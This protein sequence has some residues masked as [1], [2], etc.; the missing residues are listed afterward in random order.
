VTIDAFIDTDVIVRF[1][2]GDDPTKQVAARALFE[3]V[4]AGTETIAAP[5]T[6]IADTVFV[7]T[8]PR[9]YHLPRRQVAGL[10]RGL[11]RL[12]GFQIAE[13]PTVLR[14]LEIFET[15]TVDFGD[16]M[17]VASMEQANIQQLY[18]YNHDFDRFAMARRR[19]P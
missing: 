7:L 3:N 2:T 17:L 18:G 16:A 13:R 11:L 14:A 10:L 8:S 5:V 19:E 15:T 9:L 12:T 1:V 4:S 6:V